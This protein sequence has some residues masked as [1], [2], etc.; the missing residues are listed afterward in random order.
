MRWNHDLLLQHSVEPVGRHTA[1]ALSQ[2]LGGGK[3]TQK[4]RTDVM[5]N[6]K[7]KGLIQQV[8]DKSLGSHFWI[9]CIYRS[10]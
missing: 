4:N 7:I 6:N 1:F 2:S 8:H 3:E 5:D 10:T 9:D